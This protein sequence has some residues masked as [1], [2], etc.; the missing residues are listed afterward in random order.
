MGTLHANNSQGTTDGKWEEL[1]VRRKASF[2]FS[3]P[4]SFSLIPDSKQMLC[5]ITS[6]TRVLGFK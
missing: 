5:M 2:F 1:H 3:F 6:L 4:A